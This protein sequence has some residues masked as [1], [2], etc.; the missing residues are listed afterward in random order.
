[1]KSGI[2]K[3]PYHE[4]IFRHIG[5]AR[6]FHF[7]GE[8]LGAHFDFEFFISIFWLWMF[9]LDFLTL[10]TLAP[11]FSPWLSWLWIFSLLYWIFWTLRIWYCTF[12]LGCFDVEYFHFKHFWVLVFLNLEIFTLT[13]PDFRYLD[14]EYSLL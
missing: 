3:A 7:R 14:F 13:I 12:E 4:I 10:N 1:M 8:T 5:T 11:I 9:Y 6:C 2:N